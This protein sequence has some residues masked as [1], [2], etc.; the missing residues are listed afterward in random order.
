MQ[1]QHKKIR[2]QYFKSIVGYNNNLR[3]ATDDMKLGVNNQVNQ[4]TKKAALKL[5]A[6]G[7]SKINPPNSHPSNP[8]HKQ[9]IE[10]Q[11]LAKPAPPPPPAP[12]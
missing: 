9:A 2:Q 12:P 11:G 1:L 6:G 5:M 8:I 4:G 7:P 3:R 10:A